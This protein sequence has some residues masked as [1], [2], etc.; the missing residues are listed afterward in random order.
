MK[1]FAVCLLMPLLLIACQKQ[2]SVAK[3]FSDIG[4]VIYNMQ[5]HHVSLNLEKMMCC[6]PDNDTARVDIMKS[7][8]R[9]VV[10]M[11]SSK[12]SPCIISKMYMWN[13]LIE[14][15]RESGDKVG[16]VFIFEPKKEQIEDAIW[17]VE[18]SGLKNRIYID[19]ACVFKRD[20]PFVPKAEMYHAMLINKKDSIL[21]VGMPLTNHKVEE[22]FFNIIN[23]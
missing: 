7:G 21:L 8:Y 9:L 3:N 18:S 23:N 17:A 10:Y 13:S 14:K 16:Y 12:C 6:I 1:Y 20:N 11:D 4:N 5:S 22:L 2:K 19:T 15:T